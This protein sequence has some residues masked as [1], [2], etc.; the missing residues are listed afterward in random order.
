MKSLRRKAMAWL[1]V[2]LLAWGV[3][4]PAFAEDTRDADASAETTLAVELPNGTQVPAAAVLNANFNVD[5]AT[6]AYLN[7]LSPE[8]RARSDAY[9]EGGYWLDLFSTLWLVTGCALILALG[10]SVRM[11]NRADAQPG[12]GGYA[13]ALPATVLLRRGPG[14]AAVGVHAADGLIYRLRA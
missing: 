5:A 10:L 4:L 13:S 12:G 8:Q 14:A 9:F 3:L 2:G 1:A 11:R 7:L 6:T